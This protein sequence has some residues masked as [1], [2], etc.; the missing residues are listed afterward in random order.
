[1]KPQPIETAPKDGTHI[2]LYAGDIWIEGYWVEGLHC[3]WDTDL[4]ALDWVAAW[5]PLPEKPEWA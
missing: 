5:L 2:L 4:I 3:G 1:M